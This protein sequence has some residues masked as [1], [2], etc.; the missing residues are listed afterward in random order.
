[1]SDTPKQADDATKLIDNNWIIVL[2]KSGLGSCFAVAIKPGSVAEELLN[3][4]V[5]ELL[6]WDGEDF[7]DNMPGVVETDDFTISQA[8]YRLT[9]KATTGR[10]A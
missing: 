5:A 7:G 9:E 1:M 3:D 8:L 6:G 2:R 10:I 4:C